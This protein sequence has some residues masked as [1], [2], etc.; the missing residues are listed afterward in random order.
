MGKGD[1][2]QINRTAHAIQSIC[3][4]IGAEKVR[5]ISSDMEAKCSGGE[6]TEADESI[7][8]LSEAFVEFVEQFRKKFIP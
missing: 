1:A 7:A 8:S 6:L 3:A 2:G 4:N 5:L